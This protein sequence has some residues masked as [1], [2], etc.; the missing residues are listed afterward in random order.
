MA[1]F[2]SKSQV[3]SIL[4]MA[5]S[6]S[7]VEEAFRELAHGTATMPTRLSLSI[8]EKQG[9][10]GVMP[11]YLAHAGVLTTKIVTV[12][13]A[14]TKRHG[15]PNVLASVILSDVETGRVQAIMEG[16]Q[17]TAMRTG[18]VSG[19]ATKYLARTD[20][21]RV[22]IFGAGIQARKQLQ[23]VCEVR[24][25]RSALVY[26]TNKQSTK[27]F[28]ADPVKANATV[29]AADSPEE[30]VQES[31]I[32]ITATTSK[33]PV[34]S[35]RHIKPG[36]HINAIGAF[37]PDA[38]EVDNK[39]IST[40]KIVVD[41]IDAALA[42]AGDIIIPLKEGVIRRQNIWAELGEIVSG[43]KTGRTSEEET[44]LFKSV[45]LGIQDAAVAMIVFKKAQ[46]LGVGTR[47]DLEG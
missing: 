42:E 20:A 29:S 41:S 37:T 39:T 9:W 22:G 28:I 46:S 5:E 14:N 47:F 18:A 38:R 26:D 12:Y 8:P 43:K 17:I 11:A 24:R 2:L 4:S 1:V 25:I 21:S 13:Q 19:V 34:F 33:T 30:V 15:I 27:D 31:D 45:G 35:G 6:I 36:T 10:L 16:S 7:A 40:S 3:S 44:T 32:I 23:A